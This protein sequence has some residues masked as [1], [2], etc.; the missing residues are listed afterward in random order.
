[1]EIIVFGRSVKGKRA[2]SVKINLTS[3]SI[4]HLNNLCVFNLTILS[5]KMIETEKGD[6]IFRIFII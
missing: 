2:K 6:K 3:T 5:N 1:P 4:Y